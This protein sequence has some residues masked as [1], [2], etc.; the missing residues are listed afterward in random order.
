MHALRTLMPSLSHT[1]T[2]KH[3]HIYTHAHNQDHADY[4]AA[5]VKYRVAAAVEPNCAQLWN[6]VG[7]AFFGKQVR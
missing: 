5:L 7:M 1:L 3:T 4:D 2:H 6:N